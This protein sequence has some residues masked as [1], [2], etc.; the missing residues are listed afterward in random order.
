MR[1]RSVALA[2]LSLCLAATGAGR[3]SEPEREKENPP[4]R[5]EIGQPLSDL[6]A[7]RLDPRTLRIELRW[8]KDG[9][10]V[11]ARLFGSGTGIW[12]D[13]AAFSLSRSDV[14]SIAGAVKK[15]GFGSMPDQIGEP[16]EKPRLRGQMTVSVADKRKRVVQFADDEESEPLAALASRIIDLSR[17]RAERGVTASS[18]TDALA[19]LSSG[20]LAPETL[21]LI[22]QRSPE[23]P[24]SVGPGW[25]LHLEGRQVLG[26]PYAQRGGYGKQRRFELSNPDFQSLVRV[27]RESDPAGL[28]SSLY[29][30][31][32]TEVRIEILQWSRD[33]L[34][35]RS[36]G[37]TPQTHGDRQKAFDRVV[38]F[39]RA[40]AARVEKE[41][42]DEPGP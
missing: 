13:R 12:N 15:A 41:G 6:A 26:R 2:L 10:A 27:V 17:K 5:D 37:V 16:T 7:G 3:T 40:L 42:R 32:Y 25:L 24:D 4:H 39:L 22:S 21:S 31:D 14:L 8:L 36:P 33:L 9:S 29:A 34:A 19:K 1:R 30:S 38:D 23:R 28:P 18:L 20:V 11:T 35:R